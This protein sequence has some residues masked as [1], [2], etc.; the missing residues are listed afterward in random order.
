MVERDPHVGSVFKGGWPEVSLFWICEKTGVPMKMRADYLR[1]KA[2]ADLKSITVGDISIE[3]AIRFEISKRKYGIQPV[4]YLEGGRIVRELVRQGKA[5][6]HGTPEQVAWAQKWA[7][8]RQPEEFFFVFQAKGIAPIVRGL[9]W[10]RQGT[11]H[12]ILDGLV[13]GTKRRLRECGEAFGLLPW[14]DSRPIYDLAD[15]DLLPSATEI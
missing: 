12:T 11:T 7:E 3:N 9:T 2:I 15:E 5:A 4:V 13:I 10:P 1:L 6:I 14:L 8:H